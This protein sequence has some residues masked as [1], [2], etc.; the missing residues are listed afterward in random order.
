M[1]FCLFNLRGKKSFGNWRKW[2]FGVIKI[3]RGGNGCER[4]GG[5]SHCLRVESN[6]VWQERN[7]RKP[8]EESRK[9]VELFI[10]R[11][12]R[13]IWLLSFEKT[14]NMREGLKSKVSLSVIFLFF[15]LGNFLNQKSPNSI[16]AYSQFLLSIN[17]EPIKKDL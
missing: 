8:F 3:D 14:I 11:G 13:K 9:R 17:N 1:D 6:S 16:K 4:R 7:W 15:F 12:E 2:W 5:G 10:W